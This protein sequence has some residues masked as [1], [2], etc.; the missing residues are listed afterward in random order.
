MML[1]QHTFGWFAYA[2][3]ADVQFSPPLFTLF[4]RALLCI[5]VGG[6]LLGG[7][8]GYALGRRAIRPR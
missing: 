5:A 6:I 8:G 1:E 3:L 2:P 7:A 4:R